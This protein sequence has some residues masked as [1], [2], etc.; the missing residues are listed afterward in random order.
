MAYRLDLAAALSATL[1]TVA[2]DQLE[3]AADGLEQAGDDP[4]EAV[5]DARKRLKKTRSLLRL[6]RPGL[7]RRDYGADNRAP[8]D[9]RRAL[10]GARDADVRVETV[11]KL[12]ERFSGHVPANT[13]E[14]V[15]DRFAVRAAGQLADGHGEHADR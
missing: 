13:F 4:V 5:H 14:T 7:R 3:A 12:G 11:E 9:A 6:P 8:R 15:R 2:R 10:S 1:R